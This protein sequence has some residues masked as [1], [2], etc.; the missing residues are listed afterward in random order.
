MV[1]TVRLDKEER[2]HVSPMLPRNARGD[3]ALVGCVDKLVHTYAE[4]CVC[5]VCRMVNGAVRDLLVGTYTCAQYAPVPGVA[6]EAPIVSEEIA[7]G[8]S[9]N[10]HIA[11]EAGRI[12]RCKHRRD[13]NHY[14]A[15]KHVCTLLRSLRR[16]QWQWCIVHNVGS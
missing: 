9:I 13:C 3:A 11:A 15:Q 8:R 5:S 7:K 2:G 16:A 14:H 10:N 1:N 6:S 12:Q 4:Q